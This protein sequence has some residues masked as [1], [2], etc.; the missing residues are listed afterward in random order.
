MR[1][2]ER[3]RE[4]YQRVVTETVRVRGTFQGVETEREGQRDVPRC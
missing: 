3:E 4:T 2:R 1:E